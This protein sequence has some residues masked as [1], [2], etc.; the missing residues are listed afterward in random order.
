MTRYIEL[1]HRLIYL[2]D[3]HSMISNADLFEA[4]IQK[5][6]LLSIRLVQVEVERNV[7][8]AMVGDRP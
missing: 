8:V 2:T 4:A 7:A 5:I 1:R 6:E 3:T